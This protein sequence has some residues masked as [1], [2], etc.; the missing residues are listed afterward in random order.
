M[1]ELV[2]RTP[3]ERGM[4][5]ATGASLLLSPQQYMVRY[6]S[7]RS[8]RDRRAGERRGERHYCAEIFNNGPSGGTVLGASVLRH[9]EVIFDMENSTIGFADANCDATSQATAQMQGGWAFAPCASSVRGMDQH[10]NS[11]PRLINA[12][13]SWVRPSSLFRWLG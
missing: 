11:K 8:R 7:P 12:S 13:R 10:A 6:P 4:K 9:R 5:R 1:I 3:P 2:L